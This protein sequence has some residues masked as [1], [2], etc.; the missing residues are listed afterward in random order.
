MAV[1]VSVLEIDASANTV[2][3][4]PVG[5]GHL[6]LRRHAVEERQHIRVGRF[7]TGAQPVEN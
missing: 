5:D 2:D 7:G 4:A 6:H 3:A 1:A